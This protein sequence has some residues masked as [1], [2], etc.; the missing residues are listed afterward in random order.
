MENIAKIK[1]YFDLYRT[2]YVLMGIKTADDLI[3]AIILVKDERKLTIHRISQT[4]MDDFSYLAPFE[5]LET[6]QFQCD[7]KITISLENDSLSVAPTEPPTHLIPIVLGKNLELTSIRTFAVDSNHHIMNGFTE[8][9]TKAAIQLHKLIL[10]CPIALSVKQCPCD[11]SN[12][13]KLTLGC[14]PESAIAPIMISSFTSM[15]WLG[16]MPVLE[17]LSLLL[18]N[19]NFNPADFAPNLKKLGVVMCELTEVDEEWCQMKHLEHLCLMNT[20][21][22]EFP[23]ILST[24]PSLNHLAIGNAYT[25][26]N[27]PKNNFEDQDITIGTDFHRLKHLSILNIPFN[28]LTLF[29]SPEGGLFF[30]SLETL[31][32][33]GSTYNLMID[34]SAKHPGTMLP[35]LKTLVLEGVMEGCFPTEMFWMPRVEEY[36]GPYKLPAGIKSIDDLDLRTSAVMHNNYLLWLSTKVEEM[37]FPKKKHAVAK[38][39]RLN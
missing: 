7:Q 32:L 2:Q 27:V 34:S 5:G 11:F 25:A 31:I 36:R 19:V 20:R 6:A 38:K 3:N 21:L 22:T 39:R 14:N 35:A 30:D 28:S 29:K 4:L 12:L 16:V 18:C 33:A 23:A 1:D 15:T 26:P 37:N 10:Q 9:F 8:E 17:T 24:F 13:T